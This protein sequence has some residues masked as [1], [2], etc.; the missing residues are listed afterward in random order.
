MGLITCN[1]FSTI[2][3]ADNTPTSHIVMSGLWALFAGR[4][5]REDQ[6][7]KMTPCIAEF[8]RKFRTYVMDHIP[9]YG[10][11]VELFA[12]GN[13]LNPAYKGR[14]VEVCGGDMKAAIDRLIFNHPSHLEFLAEQAT[15]AAESTAGSDETCN[16]PM[17]Q[18]VA[19]LEPVPT[20]IVEKKSAIEQ[21]WS[22]YLSIS[23]QGYSQTRKR[24]ERILDW[25]KGAYF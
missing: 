5:Y 3:C 6:L 1:F 23:T 8:C 4:F 22:M 12:N 17:L 25:W 16:D 11:D 20:V 9:K 7:A 10:A 13:I 21:E 2:L 15:T 19:A 18:A 14:G 24:N